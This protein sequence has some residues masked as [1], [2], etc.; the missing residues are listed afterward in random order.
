MIDPYRLAED[1]AGALADATGVDRHDVAIVLGS[2]WTSA[3]EGFGQPVAEV[4]TADLPGFAAATVAGHGGRAL[5]LQAGDRRVLLLSGRVHGYEGH[6][7]AAVV[8]PVR[9]AVLSGCRTVVL[10][11]AAGGIRDGLSVG[12]PVLIAD[13]LDFTGSSPLTG[14]N[15]DDLAPR[16]PDLTDCWTSRLRDLARE[17]DP[18]LVDATYV[19]VRGPQYETPAE[20]RMFRQLGG[21]LVG[22]STVHEAVAASHLG[23]EVL[24]ISLVTNLAAG[25]GD[26]LDH[27]DVVRVAG[28]AADRMGA[29]LADLI[30]RL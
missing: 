7:P 28:E 16:F 23:A 19:G 9:T 25:L 15:R 26:P 13:H 18:S 14:P 5:S 20:I 27:A 2:G 12:Q 30:A 6:P 24:G 10:T 3:V 29:L 4:A 1:A 22:M 17:L 8:H 21:D 11:N